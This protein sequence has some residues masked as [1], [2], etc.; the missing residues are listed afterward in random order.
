[1]TVADH[2][3]HSIFKSI[4]RAFTSGDMDALATF[5]EE[6]VVWHTPLHATAN[7]EDKRLDQDYVIGF[8]VGDGKV[9]ATWEVWRDQ[10][11][12]DEF[13][14]WL[15]SG[16]RDGSGIGSHSDRFVPLE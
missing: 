14:S 1:V 2:P 6:G 16:V 15:V 8:N 5:F 7:C 4:Y 13:W 11:A 9:H 10:V 12:A 3:N